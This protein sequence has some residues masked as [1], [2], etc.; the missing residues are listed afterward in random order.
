MVSRRSLLRGATGLAAAAPLSLAAGEALAADHTGEALGAGETL[1]AEGATVPETLAVARGQVGGGTTL[2]PEVKLSHLSVRAGTDLRVKTAS[3]W[4]D[5]SA[6]G[7]T[8]GSDVATA[9]GNVLVPAAGVTAYRISSAP[10]AVTELNTADGR[11]RPRTARPRTLTLPRAERAPWRPT[12]LSRAAWGADESYR[13]NPDGTLISPPA[14]FGVQTLTVHHSG[15]PAPVDDPVQHVR[16]IYYTHAVSNGW[17]DIGYQ[18]L[19]DRYGRVFEGVYSDPG[20]I[21][22]FGPGPGAPQ[23]VN[24]AHVGG[25]NAGNIG[26]CVLGNTMIT[27]PTAAAVRSLVVV[28][29]LLAKAT[30]LDP[31]G[32][33]GYVN[34]ISGSTATLRTIS[35]HRDWHDANPAAGAT[36]CCGNHLYAQLPAIRTRVAALVDLLG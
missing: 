15:E 34:P 18:L 8:A 10:T 1:A 12:Y 29:A 17:G 23:M 16:G 24:G 7:C 14:F 4:R 33:T 31:E 35:A 27:P 28:L 3:G 5:V 13:L 30:D 36:E 6:S 9:P 2:T 20:P 22:V 25:F 21:P 26:V 11:A 32:T 19:I